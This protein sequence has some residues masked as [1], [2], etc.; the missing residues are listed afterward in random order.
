MDGEKF[1]A[2]VKTEIETFPLELANEAIARVRA[3]TV[4][5]AAVLL[6][7]R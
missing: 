7:D 4:R 5:G 3:G 2:G 6:M 1:L